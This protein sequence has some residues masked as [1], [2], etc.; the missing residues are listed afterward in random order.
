MSL[1][2]L[3][4]LPDVVGLSYRPNGTVTISNPNYV[5]TNEGMN[6]IKRSTPSSH[7]SS[8]LF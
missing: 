1:G 8:R 3:R 6:L 4:R 2:Y 5:I 7:G